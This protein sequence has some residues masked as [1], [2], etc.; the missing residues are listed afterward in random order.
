MVRI[1]NAQVVV[2]RNKG[3]G[4]RVDRRKKMDGDLGQCSQVG[5]LVRGRGQP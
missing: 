4:G 3:K 2:V 5:K 1:Q